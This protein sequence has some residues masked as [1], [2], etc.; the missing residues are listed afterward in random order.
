M[1]GSSDK[2]MKKWLKHIPKSK[3]AA[4]K[5]DIQRVKDSMDTM[6]GSITKEFETIT[7]PLK[8]YDKYLR[9]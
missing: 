3:H 9:K 7:A 5:K 4:F 8:K 1:K 2:N 6:M